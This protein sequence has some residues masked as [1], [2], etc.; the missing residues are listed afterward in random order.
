MKRITLLVALCM[1]LI[2]SQAQERDVFVGPFKSWANVKQRFGV[3][4]DG[5]AD[6]TE[7]LQLAL[8]NLS[9]PATSFNMG[10]KG[11]MTL[12]LPAGIYKISKTLVLRGKIGVSI[13]GED[14]G[15]TTILWAGKSN[16][17]M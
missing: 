12:Y 2:S 17:T 5:K 1:Q 6:D 4:G 8:D 11:Y 15:K 9:N 7:K 10:D 13:I 3:T 16:D 14:P